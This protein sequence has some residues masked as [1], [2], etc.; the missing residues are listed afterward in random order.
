VTGLRDA[1]WGTVNRLP[2]GSRGFPPRQGSF[3]NAGGPPGLLFMRI[4]SEVMRP[5]REAG[6][7]LLLLRSP[8]SLRG[9]S[10][11]RHRRPLPLPSRDTLWILCPW[12]KSVSTI[13]CRP[14][15]CN[16]WH[17]QRLYLPCSP[18]TNSPINVCFVYGFLDF[19]S[20]WQ[21]RWH[22]AQTPPGAEISRYD[23]S[24]LHS[25]R[26]RFARPLSPSSGGGGEPPGCSLHKV[27]GLG[28]ERRSRSSDYQPYP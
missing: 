22:P 11:E 9:V 28:G 25:S 16:R 4:S 24:D 20:V 12:S 27:S 6:C 26:Y 14:T 15:L 18:S 3:T 17:L 23:S 8:I 19:A 13:V 1:Y 7:L 10:T 2:T 5:E 21:H